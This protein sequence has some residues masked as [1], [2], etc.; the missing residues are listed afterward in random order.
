MLIL[1]GQAASAKPGPCLL[2]SGPNRKDFHDIHRAAAI[3][4]KQVQRIRSRSQDPCF[5]KQLGI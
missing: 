1:R 3:Y 4:R 5:L 2:G